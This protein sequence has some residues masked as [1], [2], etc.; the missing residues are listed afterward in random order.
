MEVENP[1]RTVAAEELL[2]ALEDEAEAAETVREVLDAR[3]I[4]AEARYLRERA[5]VYLAEGGWVD[6]APSIGFGQSLTQASGAKSALL[7]PSAVVLDQ[8]AVLT[9]RSRLIEDSCWELLAGGHIP[10]GLERLGDQDAFAWAGDRV[11]RHE[12]LPSLLLKRPWWRNF[13]H[14]LVDAASILAGAPGF[15]TEVLREGGGQIVIGDHAGQMAALV[16]E[17]I[18]RTVPGVPVATLPDDEIWS[19]DR[20]WYPMPMRATDRGFHPAG[21]DALR[22]S[23]RPADPAEPHRLL[24]VERPEGSARALA[25]KAGIRT[26]CEALG[27]EA[28]APE[29]MTLAAQAALFAEAN[30]IVGVKGAALTNTLFCAANRTTIVALGPE[31][32]DDDLFWDIATRYGN[33]YIEIRGKTDPEPADVPP[34]NRALRIDPRRLH[35]F[36]VVVLADHASRANRA[37]PDS[38]GDP[39]SHGQENGDRIT[40]HSPHAGWPYVDVLRMIHARLRPS[41]YFELGT[42]SGR[43]LEL[44]ACPVIAVGS[45]L[46]IER[47][48]TNGREATHLFE[49]DSNRFFATHDARMIL[50]RPIELAFMDPAATARQAVSDFIHLEPICDPMGLIIIGNCVPLEESAADGGDYGETEGILWKFVAALNKYR[51]DLKIELFDAQPAGLA[52]VSGLDPHS[53]ALRESM[54]AILHDCETMPFDLSALGPVTDGRVTRSTAELPDYLDII[55][56]G[57]ERR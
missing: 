19:F 22:R 56:A 36:L 55:I 47:L 27:F 21:A 45:K 13:G 10:R 12:T 41:A 33:D 2:R 16:R 52:I 8:G 31:R 1:V 30:V 26:V 37:V 32:W 54:P 7:L 29:T 28:V 46:R 42:E 18:D 9:A 23:F 15:V 14:W 50:G 43:S 48:R 51:R 17:T 11:T 39:Q 49:I 3:A 40:T 57:R 5:R 4:A 53:N 35:D 44:A 34:H 24:Y 6:Y 20:L 38:A 25:D